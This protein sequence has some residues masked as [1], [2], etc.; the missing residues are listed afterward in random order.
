MHSY[1]RPSVIIAALF[2]QMPA[3]QAFGLYIPRSEAKISTTWSGS[4]IAER[5]SALKMVR[6]LRQSLRLSQSLA[7]SAT[8]GLDV[9]G[10]LRLS[11]KTCAL[12]KRGRAGS[13][14]SSGF[15]ISSKIC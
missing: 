15:A 7:S 6:T 13:R 2:C 3:L 1:A 12:Q 9:W 14:R 11:P 8:A 5:E 4:Q 10:E